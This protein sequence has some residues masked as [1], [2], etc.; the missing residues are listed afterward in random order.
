[1][2]TIRIAASSMTGDEA[3]VDRAL[4]GCWEPAMQLWPGGENAG[5]PRA[6]FSNRHS[7]RCRRFAESRDT[8]LTLRP[9]PV[10]RDAAAAGEGDLGHARCSTSGRPLLPS[11]V[12]TLTTPGET[13]STRDMKTRAE[14]EVNSSDHRRVACR[15][16]GASFKEAAAAG[17]TAIIATTPSSCRV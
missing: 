9:P 14:V 17:S 15:Q 4:Y 7:G 11:P 16:A 12:T 10:D 3:V 2:T 8:G 6:V 5:N 13:R 1:M